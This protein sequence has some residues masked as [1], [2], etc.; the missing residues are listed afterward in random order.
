M[1][2][3]HAIED[4]GSVQ[5]DGAVSGEAA[6]PASGV[7]RRLR[8]GLTGTF[9]C[10]GRLGRRGPMR[11]R[12]T[13][14]RISALAILTYVV[15]VNLSYF[16]VLKPIWKRLD[17]LV[18]KKT[19]IQDFLVV[20]ESG[21]AVGSFRDALMRGDE[22]LTVVGEIERMAEDAGLRVVGEPVLLPPKVMSKKITE[23]PL[24]LT[25]RGSYH[26]IGKLLSL[27]EGA[28]RCFIVKEVELAATGSGRG[29]CDVALVLGVASWEE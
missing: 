24:E 19:V 12:G 25:L 13:V 2:L 17:G 23:Y 21:A 26:E 18:E 29:E 9:S 20:R 10:A 4:V 11:G 28:P 15:A 27:L 8:D 5:K 3:Q 22:R 16:F 7:L 6:A 14:L 1:G